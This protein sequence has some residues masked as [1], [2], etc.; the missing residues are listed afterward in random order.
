LPLR[1]S[2]GLSVYKGTD[3]PEVIMKAAD[4]RLY[5]HK[6]RRRAKQN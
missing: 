6:A 3:T 4:L 5:A 1:A 2:F